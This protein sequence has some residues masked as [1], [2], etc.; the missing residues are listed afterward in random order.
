[1]NRADA[2]IRVCVAVTVGRMGY[3]TSDLRGSS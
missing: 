2:G 1:M 3:D